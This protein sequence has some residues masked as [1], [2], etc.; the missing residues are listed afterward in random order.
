DVIIY[1]ATEGV[2]GEDVALE[3][4]AEDEIRMNHPLKFD[5]YT[6]YQ[7]GYQL[8]EFT[9]MSFKI[10]Q[11]D[12]TDAAELSRFT[13]DL[14]DP[15]SEYELDNGFK[16]ELEH[17]FP[18]YYLDENGEP[19][20]KTRESRNPAFV[21]KVYPPN[22]E[23]PEISFAGIGKN[24]DATAENEFKVGIVDYNMHNVS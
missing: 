23:K 5:G 13:V 12:D 11:V 21:F 8:N 3:K 1:K 7:A 18:D 2:V 14:T 16:V 4:V 15:D 22:T 10:Y 6:L 17:Y 20:S 24:I 19:R 9:D